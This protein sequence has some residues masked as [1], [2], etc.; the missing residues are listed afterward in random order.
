MPVTGG[1]RT[2]EISQ[3]EQYRKGGLGRWYWD[4]RDKMILPLLEGPTILDLGCGE[5]ITSE[6]IAAYFPSS[7]VFSLDVDSRNARICQENGLNPLLGDGEHLP[8]ADGVFDSVAFVEVIEHLEKPWRTL[9]EI[10]RV[11]K[12][13]GRL[14]VVYPVDN[15]MFLAR[16]LTLKWREAFFDPGHVRQWNRWSLRQSLRKQGFQQM[17]FR[18]LPLWWPFILHGLMTCRKGNENGVSGKTKRITEG[19]RAKGII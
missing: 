9:R 4:F 16:C 17:T 15:T 8:F 1:K 11:L 14:V 18:S 2:T 3:R 5:G 13:G 6:K 19:P 12:P 10:A 7:Q